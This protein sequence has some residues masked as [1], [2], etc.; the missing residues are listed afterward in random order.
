MLGGL[1]V[2][3]AQ[4]FDGSSYARNMSLDANVDVFW[5]IDDEA[6]TIR[7]AVHAKSASGWVGVGLSEMG[8]MEGADILYYETSVSIRVK[9]TRPRPIHTFLRNSCLR[10]GATAFSSRGALF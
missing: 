4:E 9:A 7:M 1:A 3:A 8:G 6:E 2:S 10:V 5:T